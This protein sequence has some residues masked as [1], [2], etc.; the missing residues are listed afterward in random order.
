MQTIFFLAK[1]EAAI[2][3]PDPQQLSGCLDTTAKQASIGLRP[4]RSASQE[5]KTFIVNHKN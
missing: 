5:A 1:G 4:K 3:K 2:I